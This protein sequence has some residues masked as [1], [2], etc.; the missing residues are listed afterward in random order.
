MAGHIFN[1]PQNNP[2]ASTANLRQWGAAIRAALTQVLGGSTPGSGNFVASD[3]NWS[4]VTLPTSTGASIGYETWKLND[5]GHA[6]SPPVY[7]KFTYTTGAVGA[8]YINIG[9]TVGTGWS[10]SSVTGPGSN[11]I[12]HLTSYTGSYG[13]YGGFTDASSSNSWMNSDGDGFVWLHAVDSITTSG[14][15]YSK[16]LLVVDRQRNPN[17]VAQ[18]NTGWPANLGYFVG[19]ISA[20]SQ[21]PTSFSPISY[22]LT[23]VVD[24]I[25][26]EAIASLRWPIIARPGYATSLSGD[27]TKTLAS[28]MWIV[29]RQGSYTSKMVLSIPRDDVNPGNVV[30][31]DF[32]NASREYKA[33]AQYTNGFD[34]VF[35]SG[36]TVALW[37]GDV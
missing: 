35:G 9:L 14:A 4:T 10:G 22:G 28:P 32:L 26:S 17:G 23:M 20:T 24:P 18:T 5:P 30:A 15:N 37:W 7:M 6:S 13:P 12:F 19:K 25:S 16:F 21:N 29:N 36:S 1:M 31:L 33:S 8:T 2:G 27:G 3:I 11:T 34:Y